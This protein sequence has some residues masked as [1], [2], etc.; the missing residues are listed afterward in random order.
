[1]IKKFVMAA[2][3]LLVLVY[4]V[5]AMNDGDEPRGIVVKAPNEFRVGQ[6]MTIEVKPEGGVQPRIVTGSAFELGNCWITARYP[7]CRR[8]R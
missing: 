8:E 3:A 2:A 4:V 6:D 5:R 7:E 1:M